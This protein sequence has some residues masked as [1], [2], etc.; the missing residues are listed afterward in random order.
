M[1]QN[2]LP[3][4]YKATQVT[5]CSVQNTFWPPSVVS[6]PAEQF[7]G[8]RN[9]S[10]LPIEVADAMGNCRYPAHASVSPNLFADPVEEM[11]LLRNVLFGNGPQ[12]GEV[13]RRDVIHFVRCLA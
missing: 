6:T 13:I 3:S 7:P 5:R 1:I 4:A 10:R 12:L 11:G 2:R 8:H 9:V